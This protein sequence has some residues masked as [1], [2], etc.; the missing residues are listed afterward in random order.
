MGVNLVVATRDS[1]EKGR[2]RMSHLLRVLLSLIP[3]LAAGATYAERVNVKYRGEVDL[4]PFRCEEVTR[5]SLVQ[6][7]CYDA[8]SSYVIVK[9]TGTY[10]HFCGVPAD[11]VR[12]WSASDSMGRYFNSNIKGRFDCRVTPPPTYR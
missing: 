4:A 1:K 12:A 3:V 11:V 2:K 6:R 10:Y 9:L 8:K 7:L 5:S